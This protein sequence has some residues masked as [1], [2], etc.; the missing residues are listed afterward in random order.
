MAYGIIRVRNLKSS[1]LAGTQK[2][3]NREYE[4]L[5]E[6]IKPNGHFTHFIE[7]YIDTYSPKREETED[8]GEKTIEDRVNER[9]A[10]AGIK[11]RKNSVYA[12]EYIVSLSPDAMREIDKRYSMPTLLDHLSHF[13]AIKHGKENVVSISHHQDE[14]NPHA[15]VVVVPIVEKEIKS[16]NRYGEKTEIKSRLCARDFT[17]GKEKLR[18]LQTDYF[19]YLHEEHHYINVNKRFPDIKFER[20]VDA[21]DR[22]A[23]GEY[24][25]KMTNHVLGEIKQEL[26]E[27]R[28]NHSKLSREEFKSKEQALEKKISAV[29]GGIEKKKEKDKEKYRKNEKWAKI[30]S[31]MNLNKGGGKNDNQISL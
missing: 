11:P 8:L 4:Q 1:D 28:E 24:Y 3:N 19:N 12:I 10:E 14:S 25:T 9:L 31:K 29:S 15:H 13:V 30:T 16:K 22:I 17:G 27:L 2:H 7:P 23:R 20:G 18:Q 21:R 6:N 5:P 26:M